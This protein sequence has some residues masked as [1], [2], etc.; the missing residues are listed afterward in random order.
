MDKETIIH[1]KIKNNLTGKSI[2]IV[3]DVEFNIY[4][5]QQIFQSID[6]YTESA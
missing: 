3:D 2:L 6:I 5:L 1:K 4:A